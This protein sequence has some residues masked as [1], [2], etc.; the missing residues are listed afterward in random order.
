MRNKKGAELSLNVVVITILVVLV[1]AIVVVIF[2]G[3]MGSLYGRMTDIFKSQPI[4]KATQ[5]TKCNG[6]CSNFELSGGKG[7]D[8]VIAF[9]NTLY[10]VDYNGD[11]TLDETEKKQYDCLDLGAS[12]PSI[13]ADEICNPPA[14]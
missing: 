11:G 6:Y 10:S 3:G 5:L 8:Y 9:C 14:N 12:C 7:E 13:E 4:D 2:S 1:L